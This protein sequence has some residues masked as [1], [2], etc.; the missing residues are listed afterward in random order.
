ML[1]CSTEKNA[2][3]LETQVWSRVLKLTCF[4]CFIFAN[5]CVWHNV[6]LIVVHPIHKESKRGK[7]NYSTKNTKTIYI[8]RERVLS[9]IIT[10]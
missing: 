2:L 4:A 10:N 5:I 8:T 6:V 1:R 3:A 7:K 9:I